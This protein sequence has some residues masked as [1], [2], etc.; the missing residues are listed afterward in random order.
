MWKCLFFSYKPTTNYF[1]NSWFIFIYNFNTFHWI[2]IKFIFIILLTTI[3]KIG[4]GIWFLI[5][6]NYFHMSFSILFQIIFLS[7][8]NSFISSIKGLK[9]SI[10]F[11]SW[12][13][14]ICKNS[15]FFW[16]DFPIYYFKIA[17]FFCRIIMAIYYL[18]WWNSKETKR[19]LGWYFVKTL[20]CCF[21][22]FLNWFKDWFFFLFH[23]YFI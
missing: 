21:H 9:I 13:T 16:N 4:V 22:Y 11:F 23:R 17:F 10:V 8:L 19:K 18:I 2:I 20:F 12:F 3:F 5:F 6:W 14:Y 1:C 15:S 7:F